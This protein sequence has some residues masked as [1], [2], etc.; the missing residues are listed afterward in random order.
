VRKRRVIAL[1]DALRDLLDD[2]QHS[3]H[4]CS[5]VDCPV[6]RARKLLDGQVEP[7]EVERYRSEHRRAVDT[8]DEAVR[9]R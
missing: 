3:E 6:S 5:D 1:E 7:A 9:K 2:T 4:D 8:L